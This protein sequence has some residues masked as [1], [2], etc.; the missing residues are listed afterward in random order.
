MKLTAMVVAVTALALAGCG[1]SGDGGGATTGAA[2]TTTEATTGAG[3]KAGSGG[4]KVGSGVPP[5]AIPVSPAG[6][7]DGGAAATE[8]SPGSAPSGPRSTGDLPDAGSA[9]VSSAV[10][11]YIAALDEHDAAAVCAS[12]A[13]GGVPLGDLPRRRGGCRSSLRASIGTH[14]AD[15]GPAWRSTRV[16]E[17]KPEALEGDRARVTATVTH[18]FSDR[19]YVSVEDDVIY[20]ERVA[21][22]W[23]IAQ[24][25][26]TFYRAVG[27]AQPPLRA[28]APPRGW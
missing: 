3:A 24:P 16:V 4:A 11:R 9:A 7:G 17:L 20:L 28:F 15:G 23:L 8:A 18:R 25:S 19:N 5:A 21:G 14:P 27:Y 2:T 1:G 10:R 13:P 6:G 22:R 12:I 26:A